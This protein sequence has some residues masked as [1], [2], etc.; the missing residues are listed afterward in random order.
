VSRSVLLS[1][2]DVPLA[3][4]RQIEA[5]CDA[6]EAAWTRQE[7]PIIETYLGQMDE[8]AREPLLGE[9][10]ALEV[11]HRRAAGQQP[12][13]AEYL[14]RFPELD[15]DWLA[16][17]LPA[18]PAP[19]TGPG[20]TAGDTPRDCPRGRFGDYEILEPLARGGMGVVY[21]ARQLSLNRVVALKMILAGSFASPAEVQRFQREAA[22]VAGL[23]HPN[24]VPVYEVGEHGG[25]HFFSM[26][27]VEG[28]S[29]APLASTARDDQRRAARIV[30]AVARAV[31]YAHQHGIL[32]RDLKP[33]NILLAADTQT[34]MVTD[35]GLAKVVDSGHT[36]THTGVI[37]GTPGY[38]A[39]EQ[40]R[41]DKALTTAIDVFGLGA[42][43]YELLTGRPPFRGDNVLETLR[44]VQE[45]E[46]ER[47]RTLDRRINL[48]LETVCL[49]CLDK[50]PQR[51]YGSAEALAEDLER[52]CSG[53]PIRARR[54]GWME[55]VAKWTK[56]RPA[57]AGL[58]TASGI[59][60]LA[61]VGVVVGLLYN[62][63]LEAANAD[64]S[65][66]TTQLENA[67][68]VTERAYGQAK[69]AA[70]EAQKQKQ[71][72][73]HQRGRAADQEALARR[74]LYLAQINLADRAIQEKKFGLAIYHL[75]KIPPRD[76]GQRDLRG[77]EWYHL[78]NQCPGDP[79]TLPR[80]HVGKVVAVAFDGHGHTVTSRGIDQMEK[81]WDLQMRRLIK[82]ASVEV[83]AL[84]RSDTLSASSLDGR[85]RASHRRPT[86]QKSKP[87]I[88]FAENDK[89]VK[90]FAQHTDMILQLAV[91][92]DGRLVASSGRD[93]MVHVWEGVTAKVV[94]SFHPPADAL[95]LAFSADGT[96]LATGDQDGTVRVWTIAPPPETPLLQM[97]GS[98]NAVAFRPDGSLLVG[99]GSHKTI[100]WQFPSLETVGS[101]SGVY[102]WGRGTF[103]AQG[104]CLSDGCSLW[105]TEGKQLGGLAKRGN[106]P[107][108]VAFS[109]DGKCIATADDRAIKV[110]DVRSRNE[111]TTFPL[112]AGDGWFTCVAIHPA[113][114]L[115]ALGTGSYGYQTRPTV[116]P[117]RIYL[118]DMTNPQRPP[119]HILD[120]LPYSTYRLAFSPDGKQMAAAC[121]DYQTNGN[122]GEVIVW[123]TATWK[124]IL[125][126][127]GFS[128]CV[129]D[130]SFSRDGLRLAT[131]SGKYWL[132]PEE[133]PG[134]VKIWDMVAGQEIIT[135][136]GH[137]ACVY[138]V[139]F[140]P[141]GKC[142]ASCDAAGRVRLWGQ[143][144][145]K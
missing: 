116:I 55:R 71:E 35:F 44:W 73:D 54:A 31:H 135:L 130:V 144:G 93:R 102:D 70:A 9:L 141:D 49:K 123:D 114:K 85:F 143:V 132:H 137:T 121:G 139:A 67:K 6:F 90:T 69:A 60:V 76:P 75:E 91:S 19:G 89:L 56:R 115:L 113:G 81:T 13:S 33:A 45:R 20:P 103:N 142:L 109:P 4:A 99:F 66:A 32:H 34:P 26:K 106:G 46:P 61:L 110:W 127:K 11:H 78:W 131:A 28:G 8:A 5:V 124:E 52:W 86:T 63:D 134:E 24:I 140:H 53:E 107:F 29:L 125:T 16:G 10:V 2:A 74:F 65:E 58:V 145:G 95:A 12:E 64:L 41:G 1:L 129:F 128:G 77:P 112:P 43:L 126:L 92:A 27:L 14:A 39:P 68:Q 23:D 62:A 79:V 42:V 47:P 104:N 48:D 94:R 118:H 105:S 87:V 57:V 83:P 37:I 80:A 38:M 36:L 136:R 111:L 100:A 98:C 88:G 51:R 82:T 101:W 133:H 25:R 97:E 18:R 96:K 138:G 59:A 7:Q 120:H 30:A 117:G 22:A 119:L 108:D 122:D 72:A 50:D 40:A 3:V 15:R 84:K 21:K 17:I